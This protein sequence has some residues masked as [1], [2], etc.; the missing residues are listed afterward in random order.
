MQSSAPTFADLDVGRHPGH[1][2]VDQGA[3]A[4]R[5][6]VL[7]ERSTPPP[8]CRVGPSGWVVGISCH[9]RPP[10]RSVAGRRMRPPVRMI[11][12]ARAT[13]GLQ[14][15]SET[16]S[17]VRSTSPT[18]AYCTSVGSAR[19]DLRAAGA[20]HPACSLAWGAGTSRT[21][22]L[23]P[24]SLTV[25]LES[26][27]PIGGWRRARIGPPIPRYGRAAVVAM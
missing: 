1:V 25:G 12:A 21:L 18:C 3:I 2:R 5:V 11:Q 10:D 27:S 6:V 23:P 14:A 17:P 16:W 24:S 22:L 4:W 20:G 15:V 8:L 26:I 13:I 9:G 7:G 19:T